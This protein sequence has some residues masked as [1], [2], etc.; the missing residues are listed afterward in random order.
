MADLKIEK[1]KKYPV[2]W[3]IL[4]LIVVGVLAW[5]II[6]YNNLGWEDENAESAYA[7]NDDRQSFANS[8]T[9]DNRYNDGYNSSNQGMGGVTSEAANKSIQDFVSFAEESDS[10]G[11]TVET[12]YEGIDKLSDAL[13]AVSLTDSTGTNMQG[14]QTRLNSSAKQRNNADKENST[15]I[16][17]AFV[18]AATRIERIQSQY[19]TPGDSRSD[20]LMK[21]AMNIEAQLPPDDQKAEIDTFFDK[22]AYALADIHNKHAANVKNRY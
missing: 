7:T 19:N 18:D 11:L 16:R 6:D 10:N 20:G 4:G 9:F 2:V 15:Y 21:A 8:D 13:V 5:L 17:D 14:N 1:K 22:A 3:I 12:T